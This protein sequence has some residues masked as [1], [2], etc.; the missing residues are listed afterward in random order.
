LSIVLMKAICTSFLALIADLV[1]P[2]S[3]S[4]ITIQQVIFASRICADVRNFLN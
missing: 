1:L 2:G 4:T 3:L